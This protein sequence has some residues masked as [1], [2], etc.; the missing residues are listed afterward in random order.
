MNKLRK[1]ILLKI[2]SCTE[3]VQSIEHEI[4]LREHDVIGHSASSNVQRI[5]LLEKHIAQLEQK[6]RRWKLIYACIKR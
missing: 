4:Y 5:R 2:K 6:K 3:Q 1:Y